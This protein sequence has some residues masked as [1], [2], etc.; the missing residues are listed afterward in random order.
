[1][2][3]EGGGACKPEVSTT[4]TSSNIQG[5][6]L[7]FRCLV[8]LEER[9]NPPPSFVCDEGGAVVCLVVGWGGGRTGPELTFRSVSHMILYSVF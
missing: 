9:R 3:K 5:L 7:A 8:R 2:D 6:F 1:M 4:A